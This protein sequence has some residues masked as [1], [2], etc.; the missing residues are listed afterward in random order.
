MRD[1]TPWLFAIAASLLVTPCIAVAQNASAIPMQTGQPPALLRAPQTP[2]PW[3]SLSAAQQQMLAPVHDQW[4]ELHPERQH[5]LA[6]HALHWVTLPPKHQ[7][8][9]QERLA[10]WADMTPTER[11]QLRE[12]ARAFRDLTPAER[13]KVS[14]AYRKFQS[15]SPAER[16]ALHA[17]WHAMPPTQR[18]HWAAEHPQ[19]SQPIQMHPPAGSGR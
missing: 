19:P 16:R 1:V 2:V 6:E 11:R 18:L 14:A 10:H 5:R 13:A 17:R 3:T 12:N 9:I 7:Q 8:K 4:N 15:L